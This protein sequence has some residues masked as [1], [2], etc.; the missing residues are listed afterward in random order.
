MSTPELS[1]LLSTSAARHSHLCP[2]QVLGVRMGLAGLA[3]FDIP[4]PNTKKH[5]LVISETDGCFVDGIEAATG[6]T[7]GHRTL[8][9]LDYGK[10]AATFVDTRSAQAFRLAPCLDIRLRARDYS[11]GETRHYFTQLLGY[12]VMPDHELFT[13]TQVMLNQPLEAILS[14][15]GMRV[16]CAYCGEEI[17]NERQVSLGGVLLCRTCAGEGYYTPARLLPV[18]ETLTDIQAVGR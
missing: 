5:L 9:I 18:L 17:I 3:L 7:V 12:Q 11:P 1:D 6:A 2:R 14:Q 4:R 13:C 16:S 8:R 10:V 15:P